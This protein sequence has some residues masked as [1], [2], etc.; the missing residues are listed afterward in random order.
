MNFRFNLFIKILRFSI[1]IKPIRY[2]LQITSK[3]F[4]QLLLE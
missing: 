2:L 3:I 4:I 1:K